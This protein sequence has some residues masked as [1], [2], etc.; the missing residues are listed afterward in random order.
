MNYEGRWIKFNTKPR[1]NK[2]NWYEI[3]FFNKLDDK[4][5]IVAQFTINNVFDFTQTFTLVFELV[6]IMLVVTTKEDIKLS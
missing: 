3:I 5:N 6:I 4:I 1:K 2:Y